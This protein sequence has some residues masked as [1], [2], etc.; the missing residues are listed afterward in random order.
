MKPPV[1]IDLIGSQ[2]ISSIHMEAL[3]DCP[4]ARGLPVASR[5]P[6]NAAACGKH[7][8]IE[9]P[10][11]LNLGGADRMTAACEANN[12]KHIRPLETRIIITFRYP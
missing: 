3:Q 4:Q 7:V 9:N 6:G 11:S 1:R 10:L 5:A 2:F 12:A 8:V